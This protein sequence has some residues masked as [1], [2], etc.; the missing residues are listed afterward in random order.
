MKLPEKWY[1]RIYVFKP[2]DIEIVKQ[3]I[4][5]MDEFE[6]DYLPKDLITT[7]AGNIHYT[8]THKFYAIDMDEL[9]AK[10]A[11]KGVYMFYCIKQQ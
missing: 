9:I 6:Y 10:C 8:F 4:K 11:E 3:T 2:T 5:E 1:A 7:F